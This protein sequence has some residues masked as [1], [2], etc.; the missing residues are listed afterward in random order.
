MFQYGIYRWLGLFSPLPT[1][2]PENE[3]RKKCKLEVNLN[4]NN[5]VSDDLEAGIDNAR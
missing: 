4:V 3:F 2:Y 5:N 1:Q